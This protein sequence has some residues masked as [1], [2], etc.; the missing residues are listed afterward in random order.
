MDVHRVQG[1]SIVMLA[2]AAVTTEEGIGWVAL[3]E[4]ALNC[5]ERCVRRIQ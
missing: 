5:G 1:I 4:M 3:W 2:S